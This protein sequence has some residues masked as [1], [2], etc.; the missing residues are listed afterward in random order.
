MSAGACAV[1]NALVYVLHN[2]RKHSCW[3]SGI[4]PFSSGPWFGGYRGRATARATA[5]PTAP[6]SWIVSTVFPDGSEW[7][8][9]GLAD[10]ARMQ[11]WPRPVR[12]ARSWLLAVGWR[13]LGTIEVDETP[14]SA[15]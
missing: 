5:E 6:R 11:S 13:R 7:L 14:A 15:A 2:A 1:R 3:G 9:S 10:D 4:D 8:I 12:R